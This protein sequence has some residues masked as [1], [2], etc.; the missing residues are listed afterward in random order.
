MIE[1][2]GRGIW[3]GSA[4]S[5]ATDQQADSIRT[6]AQDDAHYAR[7]VV[8]FL[9]ENGGASRKEINE[10]FSKFLPELLDETQ[11]RSKVTNLLTRMRKDGR[12]YNSGTQQKPRRKLV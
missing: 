6:R 12:I 11:R 5:A 7:L 4:V 10:L 3:I 9:T 2:R 1:G 8:D